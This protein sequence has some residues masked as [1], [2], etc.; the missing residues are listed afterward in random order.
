MG[1]VDYHDWL[2]ELYSIKI[3][4]NKVVLITFHTFTGHGYDICL[5]NPQKTLNKDE[6]LNLKKLRRAA[7]KVAKISTATK[8][9]ETDENVTKIVC[10]PLKLL[11]PSISV[12]KPTMSSRILT[13]TKSPSSTQ[14]H[15]LMST[16]SVAVTTSSSFP[17]D[18]PSMNT[19]SS[20]SMFNNLCTSVAPSSSNQALSPSTISM[21]PTLPAETSS[22]LETTTSIFNTI[23][24]TF[25]A[26]K[27]TSKPRR[28]NLPNSTTGRV[29]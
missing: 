25:Q 17:L 19:A 5:N 4:G 2:A 12:P 24:S 9:T 10:P 27:Y 11:Q 21:F 20:L 3:R 7:T 26:S 15:L 28:K 22:V 18:I 16:F 1:D 14:A 23:P 8:K 13:V 29:R 6:D